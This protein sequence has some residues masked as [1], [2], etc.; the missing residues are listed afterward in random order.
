MSRFGDNPAHARDPRRAGA[1]ATRD[2]SPSTARRANG[3]S[4]RPAR[5]FV[6][7]CTTRSRSDGSVF[8]RL[9]TERASRVTAQTSSD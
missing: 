1:A 6:T 9:T 4:L 7:P 5:T 3:H 8:G 2:K